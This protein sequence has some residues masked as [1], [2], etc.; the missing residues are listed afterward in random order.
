MAYGDVAQA[1]ARDAVATVR[2]H[3]TLPITAWD[4]PWTG[5]GLN[6]AQGAR[7]AKVSLL[8]WTPY[9]DTLYLDADTRVRGD[10]SAGFAMLDDG[11]DLVMAPSDHQGPEWL[12]HVSEKERAETEQRYL[13]RPVQLQAGVFFVRDTARTRAL[14]G[15]WRA[16]WTAHQGEDQAALLRALLRC[17]VRLWLLGRPWNG[18]ALI[19]H[20]F[21]RCRG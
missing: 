10:V 20:L 11:W 12:W 17:P 19:G 8:D 3:S 2:E 14:F 16:E 4:K 21:G 9:R 7:R 1:Q 5:E 13:F 18:G 15:A 6:N